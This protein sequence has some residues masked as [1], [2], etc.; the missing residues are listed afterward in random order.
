[1]DNLNRETLQKEI[2]RLSLEWYEKGIQLFPQQ[3]RTLKV[4]FDLVGTNAGTAQWRPTGDCIVRFNLELALQN[5][6]DALSDTVPHEV[7]HII[8]DEFSRELDKVLGKRNEPH[9]EVWKL[10]MLGFGINPDKSRY[11]NYNVETVKHQRKSM[12]VLEF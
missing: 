9:G 7:A 10:V 3:R 6:Q 11:H 1:M 12:E 8:A 5:L 4:Q 2:E